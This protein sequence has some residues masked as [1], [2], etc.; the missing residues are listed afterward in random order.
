MP[1]TSTCMARLGS[2]FSIILDPVRREIHYGALGLVCQTPGQFIVGLDDGK[3]NLT[4]LPLSKVGKPFDVADQYQ[5]MT[6]VVYEA[7]RVA[8]E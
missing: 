8:H 7:W 5:M 2:R 4:T 1:L 6:S 3:G